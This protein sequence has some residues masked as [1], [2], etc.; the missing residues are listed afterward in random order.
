LVHLVDQD[1]RLPDTAVV[2]IALEH[3]RVRVVD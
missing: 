1:D 3:D 2:D